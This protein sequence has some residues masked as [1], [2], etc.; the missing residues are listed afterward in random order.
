MK[1]MTHIYCGDGK[2]KTT[3]AVGLGVRACGRGMPVLM[4][5]FLKGEDSGERAALKGMAG[6]T[7][8]PNPG[9]MKFTFQMTPGELEQAKTLCRERFEA[10]VE[11]ARAG[12]C[13][14]LILDEV[15]DAVNCG[16][17]PEEDLTGFLL[18]RPEDLEVVLT[19]RNPSEPLLALADYVSE[20]KKV[21]HPFDRKIPARKG[22]EY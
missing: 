7:L 14:L 8:T 13:R 10:A 11:A 19:G 17:L 6:F 15:L 4:V 16:L 21:K 1:G 18:S 12:R 22:I 5:Q 2:G 3:A 20:M 9:Q